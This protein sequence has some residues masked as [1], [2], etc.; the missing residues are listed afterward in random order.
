M[1]TNM[2]DYSVEQPAVI[3]KICID[4]FLP[5]VYIPA[6]DLLVEAF[7]TVRSFSL[8]M[9]EGLISN[10]SAILRILIEQVSALTVICKNEKAMLSFI[11]MQKRKEGYYSKWSEKER[12]DFKDYL[13]KEYGYNNEGAVKDY[14]DY[15]WI[16]DINDD[17]SQ[18]SDRLII[19]S[20]HLEEM[21]EDINN[22]LNAFAHGQ[23]SSFALLR[24]KIY[25][26]KHVSRII[27]AAGKL[28][29]F[30]CSAKQE[31][32]VNG[33]LT[34]DKYFNSYLN[35]KILYTD[36]NSRAVSTRINEIVLGS[37]D[38]DREICYSINTL[39]HTRGL[40]YQAELNLRQANVLA[41][42]YR[43]N[44]QSITTMLLYK[45]FCNTVGE[46]IK[47]GGTFEQIVEACNHD[48]L[49]EI[50]NADS[51]VFPLDELLKANKT[52]DDN[53]CP[54]LETGD[55][56]ELDESF[57]NDFTTFVHRLFMIA[58]PN[59]NPAELIGQFISIN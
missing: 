32:L 59:V 34:D 37:N 36:L 40:L 20:A 4:I 33:Y 21:I 44:L 56:A 49:N 2:S 15:G 5:Q 57:V 23:L 14:L 12:K 50:Y 30:L 53:W 54:K 24:D 43:Y 38:L 17:R 7:L 28:F 55:F 42:A 52:I 9:L 22:T 16:R 25:A 3:S 6:V 13:R 46:T 31:W 58:F 35:A 26:D 1:L 48:K 10:A 47:N 39:D 45:V 41:V 8:L 19:K 11:A 29:L 27:M 51:H 18:R